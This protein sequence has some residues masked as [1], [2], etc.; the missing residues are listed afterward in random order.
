VWSRDSPHLDKDAQAKD[1]A[2]LMTILNS[3]PL[4]ENNP[5]SGS[6]ENHVVIQGAD[7]EVFERH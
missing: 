6:P 2:V 7:L 5:Q 1:E 4:E 3:P